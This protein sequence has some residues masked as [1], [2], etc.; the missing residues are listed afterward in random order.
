[1][2]NTR[3]DYIIW[4]RECATKVRTNYPEYIKY[5]EKYQLKFNNRKRAFGVCYY[6]KI[7]KIE[8]SEYLCKNMLEEEVKDTILHEMAHAVDAGVRGYS[9]HDKHWKKIAIELG[10]TP[11]SYSKMSKGIEYKYVC[12]TENNNNNLKLQYGF[13][14][15]RK[16]LRFNEKLPN[17]WIKGK[18]ATTINKLKFLHWEDWVFYCEQNELSPFIEDWLK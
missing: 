9:N 15:K 17:L 7:K 13:N 3:K 4:W 12:V 8:L 5:L 2:S 18:K 14:R 16:G 10:A 11:R 6:G 1:M